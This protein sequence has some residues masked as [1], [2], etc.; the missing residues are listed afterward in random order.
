MIW[1]NVSICLEGLSKSRETSQ[2][3]LQTEICTQD[4]RNKKTIST[5][6]TVKFGLLNE[7]FHQI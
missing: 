4:F 3:G 1:D 5:H 2:S 7:L 6:L